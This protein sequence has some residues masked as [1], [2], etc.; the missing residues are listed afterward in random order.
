MLTVA[1]RRGR[2]VGGELSCDGL[3]DGEGG[4]EGVELGSGG[5]G[6][7]EGGGEGGVLKYLCLFIFPRYFICILSPYMYIFLCIYIYILYMVYDGTNTLRRMHADCRRVRA[8]RVGTVCE[9]M[10]RKG[11]RRALK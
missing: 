4:D 8:G 11:L 6:G 9:T 7:G 1:G 2:R 10:R 5:L 3:E